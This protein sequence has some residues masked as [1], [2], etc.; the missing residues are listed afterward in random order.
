MSRRKLPALVAGLA[1]LTAGLGIGTWALLRPPDGPL[2]PPA[3]PWPTTGTLAVF[4]CSSTPTA[5]PCEKGAP[6]EAERRVIEQTLRD[7]PEV[8]DVRFESQPAMYQRLKESGDAWTA[9]IRVD[10]MPESYR[11]NLTTPGVRTDRLEALPGVTS[12][13]VNGASFWADKADLGIRLCLALSA[14]DAC[15]DRD[16]TVQERT[17]VYQALR[18]IDGVGAIYL[19][20]SEHATKNADRVLL[21]D[22]DLTHPEFFH[23]VLTDPA[24]AEQVK[25]TVQAMPGVA[26]IIRHR[27]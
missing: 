18:A 19:E 27:P 5:E 7:M 9:E 13:H 23:V 24:V 2:P 26:G 14:E 12:V 1:L 10:D 4:L 6:T 21:R 20:S 16:T 22:L 11:A 3:G 17:A 25:R 8:S 15:E